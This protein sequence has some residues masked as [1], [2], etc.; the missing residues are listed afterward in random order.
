MTLFNYLYNNDKIKKTFNKKT[1]MW[2][3]TFPQYKDGTDIC[4]WADD[5]YFIEKIFW[6]N[7]TNTFYIKTNYKW[8]TFINQNNEVKS[9]CQIPCDNSYEEVEIPSVKI[10]DVANNECNIDFYY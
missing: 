2:I 6:N 4:L 3:F 7:L 9:T 5:E 1:Y 10:F 8:F